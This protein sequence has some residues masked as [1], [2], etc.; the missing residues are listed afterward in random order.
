[1]SAPFI[2]L[3]ALS[4]DVEPD[5]P[6]GPD[7]EFDPD[8]LALETASAGTPE[9]QYGDNVYPAEPPDWTT[10]QRLALAL[11]QRSR[12]VRLV[13]WLIRSGA[14]LQGFGAV[15]QGL[16]LLLRLLEQRWDGLHPPLDASDDNDPTMRLNALLPLA[17]DEALLADL[18]EATLAPVRGSLTFRQLELTFGKA[19]PLKGE[20]VPGEAALIAGLSELCALHPGLAE[21]LAA[22]E[23]TVAAIIAC[24][25][26][27]VGHRA[28]DLRP[29]QRLLGAAAAAAARLAPQEGG[30]ADEADGAAAQAPTAGSA[31]AASGA[32]RGREDVVRE[33]D[34]LCL[35]LEHNEPGHPAPLLLRRAQRLMQM[36]FME[37]IREMAP[38]GLEQVQTVVGPQPE[39]S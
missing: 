31:V 13:V 33:L 5:A 12:D 9:R 27:Q 11:A 21:D 30:V 6:C 17:S 2:D 10:V 34:R 15:V 35:W 7:L 20:S 19:E 16:R 36:N 22:A 39:Q 1:M 14:H 37:I 4:A 8:F 38:N 23:P 26:A 24:V 3:D 29:L 18:R 32:V 28:P 25:D